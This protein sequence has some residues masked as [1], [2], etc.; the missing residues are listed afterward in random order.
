MTA[1]TCT[2]PGW[3][4]HAIAFQPTDVLGTVVNEM[5]DIGSVGPH[6]SSPDSGMCT[7]SLQHEVHQITIMVS[8]V[9]TNVFMV[10]INRFMAA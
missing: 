2:L 7:L 5:D 6:L 4:D 3:T 8:R 10:P 9:P 1:W